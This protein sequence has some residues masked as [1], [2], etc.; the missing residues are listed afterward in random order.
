MVVLDFTIVNV[1]LPSIQ[2]ELHVATTTLQWLI[3]AYAVTFGGFLLLG[4]R[5]ADSYGRARLYRIGL[6]VFVVASVSGGL[7]V[8]PGLLIASRV[9]QGI[10]ATMLAPAG[11]SLLVTSYPGEQERSRA[12]GP[13]ARSSRRASRR[14]R[15]SAGCSRSA[16]GW[17]FVNVPI[18][19]AAG[20]LSG[21]ARSAVRGSWTAGAVTATAGSPCWCGRAPWPACWP[22]AVQPGVPRAA[23]A[24][25]TTL[26]PGSA[27]PRRRC[28]TW[29][30]LSSA[31]GALAGRSRP[32]RARRR[33][34]APGPHGP[35]WR[36]YGKQGHDKQGHGEERP[37]RVDRSPAVAPAGPGR[38]RRGIGTTCRGASVAGM[39]RQH[40]ALAGCPR[41]LF[42]I[43][44]AGVN[45][46]SIYRAGDTG[47][48]VH[49]S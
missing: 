3:S 1:A 14:A 48:R 23:I 34:P 46:P 20:R 26:S 47:S 6:V 18:G 40:P 5:L 49:E 15:C 45:W 22:P 17:L 27:G 25:P 30:L 12:R 4:G 43:C 19:I 36:R 8:E 32:V 28:S 9:V 42:G 16:G 33:R 13:T 38:H 39:S 2:S 35:S 29:R 11:L 10:G 41:D 21:A 7:A 44:V 37:V 24:A 31:G